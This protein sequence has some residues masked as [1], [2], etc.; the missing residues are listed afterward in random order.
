[1]RRLAAGA[2]GALLGSVLLGSLLLAACSSAPPQALALGRV[3][4]YDTATHSVTLQADAAYAGINGQMNFD[5]YAEG[6]LTIHV[7][8]G[9]LVTVECHNQSGSL[10]HSCAIID[11]TPADLGR[12]ATP[13]PEAATPDPYSGMAPRHSASFRFVANRV[14]DFR[15]ACLVH[16][17]E[18]DG[19]WDYFDITPGGRPAATL[20]P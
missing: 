6:T 17:H 18:I 16:G 5:G 7:P 20:G 10:A 19:M 8:Y 4:S 1:M 11:N 3:L 15:L 2:L 12:R 13:F 14:G 9:W